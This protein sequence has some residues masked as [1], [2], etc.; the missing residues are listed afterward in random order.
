MGSDLLAAAAGADHWHVCEWLLEVDLVWNSSG[1]GGAAHGGHVDLMD[2][3]LQL[4]LQMDDGG[5]P[6]IRTCR[7]GDL[8]MVRLLRRLGAP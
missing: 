8:A 2:W 4:R 1:I 5:W 7:N 3:L 6:Y